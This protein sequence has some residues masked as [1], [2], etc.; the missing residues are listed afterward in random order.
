MSQTSDPDDGRFGADVSSGYDTVQDS[1]M[2][3][4]ARLAASCYSIRFPYEYNTTR[5]DVTKEG[6]TSIEIGSTIPKEN[7]QFGGDYEHP[8]GAGRSLELHAVGSIKAVI[9]K[10][11]DE[12]EAIDL[13]ALGQVV[14]RLGADD[15]SLPTRGAQY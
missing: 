12:E 3:A 1:D 8:H 10:N 13:Q 5:L 9:G 14:M 4:E 2:H 11:R 15:T 6:F 7:N